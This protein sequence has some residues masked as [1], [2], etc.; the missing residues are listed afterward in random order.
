MQREEEQRQREVEGRYQV[1]VEQ[2]LVGIYIQQYEK[3]VYVNPK[4]ASTLG[5][6][7]E[8]LIGC[9]MADLLAQ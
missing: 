7:Q 8:E 6:Q 9:S 4:V 2:S 5:Y 3:L 1:L